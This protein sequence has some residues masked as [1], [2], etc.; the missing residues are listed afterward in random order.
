MRKVNGYKLCR[1]T[2]KTYSFFLRL[3]CKALEHLCFLP[4]VGCLS[5]LALPADM[6]ETDIRVGLGGEGGKSSFT[7]DAIQCTFYMVH[8]ANKER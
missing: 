3:S 8:E 2:S 7:C 6:E 4:D 1:L 5:A